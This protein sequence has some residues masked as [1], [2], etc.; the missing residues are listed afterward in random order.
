MAGSQSE[1]ERQT[2]TDMSQTAGGDPDGQLV[3]A[4]PAAL[5]VARSNNVAGGS[6]YDLWAVGEVEEED[7]LKAAVSG[8]GSGDD[9]NG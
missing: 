5:R 2:D 6:G 8:H 1:A 9:A 3:E 7:P 4:D